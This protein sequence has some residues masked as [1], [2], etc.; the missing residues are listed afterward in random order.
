MQ[1]SSSS[2]SAEGEEDV[3]LEYLIGQVEYLVTFSGNSGVKRSMR[4]SGGGGKHTG[5]GRYGGGGAASST[6]SGLKPA[7]SSSEHHHHQS[8]S[9]LKKKGV[10]FATSSSEIRSSG[11]PAQLPPPPHPISDDVYLVRTSLISQ[12][13]DL[14]P[15]LGDGFIEVYR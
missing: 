7:I 14:F 2:T 6:G 10:S 12:V 4:S 9:S 8:D 5:G 1:V 3:R 13:Q 15:E 11:S